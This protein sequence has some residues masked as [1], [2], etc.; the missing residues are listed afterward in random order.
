[1]EFA[2]NNTNCIEIDTEQIPCWTQDV[3]SAATYHLLQGILRQPGGREALNA[4]ISKR[5]AV[6]AAE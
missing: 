5:K 2:E 3:L 6:V 4:R 1:M